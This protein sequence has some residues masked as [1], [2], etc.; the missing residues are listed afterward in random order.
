MIKEERKMKTKVKGKTIP[1]GEKKIYE[2]IGKVS[3]KIQ[4][5]NY[6]TKELFYRLSIWENKELDMI[7]VYQRN[8]N[9]KI[10][11]DVSEG[12]YYGKAYAFFCEKVASYFHLKDWKEIK[13]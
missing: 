10:W 1:R 8:V 7:S 13:E 6:H 9:E 4:E 5:K 2:F 3:G 12:N 11:K